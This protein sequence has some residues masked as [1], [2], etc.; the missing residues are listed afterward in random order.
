MKETIISFLKNY[1]KILLPV[2]TVFLVAVIILVIVLGSGREIF[3]PND[4]IYNRVQAHVTHSII[5]QSNN[6]LTESETSSEASVSESNSEYTESSDSTYSQ[7]ETQQEGS[8]YDILGELVIKKDGDVLYLTGFEDKA[9]YYERDGQKYILYYD[10]MYGMKEDNG[11]WVERAVDEYDVLFYFDFNVLKSIDTNRLNKTGKEYVPDEDYMEELLCLIMRIDKQNINK[12]TVDTI[13]FKFDKNK[14]RTIE[15]IYIY[16]NLTNK[17]T[18][19]FT[20]NNTALEL[21]Q[22]DRIY[23][24]N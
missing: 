5:N 21:P 19:E 7:E 10:D 2:A 1:K 11:D 6:T 24:E 3:D 18:V 12:Y 9:Y 13:S 16:N 23:G 20:Y 4:K 14:L 15:C 22:V 8:E 17:Y